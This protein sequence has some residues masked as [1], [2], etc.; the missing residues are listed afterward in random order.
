MLDAPRQLLGGEL[1]EPDPSLKIV[2]F[3]RARA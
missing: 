1:T 3:A 2:P